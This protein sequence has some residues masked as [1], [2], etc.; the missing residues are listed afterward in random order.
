LFQLILKWKFF[1]FQKAEVWAQL[2]FQV[3]ICAA[4]AGAGGGV[5][6]LGGG[7]EDSG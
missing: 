6:L 5:V 7:A 1:N 2:G 4:G 3:G